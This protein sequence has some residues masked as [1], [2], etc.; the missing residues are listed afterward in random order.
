MEFPRNYSIEYRH[1]VCT[2]KTKCSNQRAQLKQMLTRWFTTVLPVLKSFISR[3][4]CSVILIGDH[5][6]NK[7]KT[8]KRTLN[9]YTISEH[10][11]VRYQLQLLIGYFGVNPHSQVKKKKDIGKLNPN[12]KNR[13]TF[14]GQIGMTIIIRAHRKSRE[15]CKKTEGENSLLL[16]VSF[17]LARFG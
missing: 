16:C 2:G 12:P 8:K 15:R 1:V 3:P 11:S 7:A 13:E 9:I 17:Q 5:V 6:R 10:I 14:N 4:H